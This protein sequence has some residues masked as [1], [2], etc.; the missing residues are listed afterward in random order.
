MAKKIVI[1]IELKGGENVEK[2]VNA[3]TKLTKEIKT[4]K[5]ELAKFEVGTEGYKKASAALNE[6]QE[7]LGDVQDAAKITGNGF[8]RVKGS[9]NLFKESLETADFGKAKAAFSALGTAMKA[10]PIFLLLEGINY[11]IEKFDL[12]G[13]A[14]EFIASIFY[15]ITDAM[16]LTAKESEENTKT[17][18]ENYKKQQEA[19]EERYDAEIAAANIAGKNTIELEKKKQDAIISSLS[20]QL[21]ALTILKNKKGELNEDE[22]KEFEELQKSLTKAS[23]DRHLLELKQIQERKEASKNYYDQAKQITEQSTTLG[24]SEREKEISDIKKKADEQKKLLEDSLNKRGA[25]STKAYEEDAKLKATIDE[26]AQKE[27]NKINKKYG[28]EYKANRKDIEATFKD[29][30]R[31]ELL[32]KIALYEETKKISGLTRVQEIELY[33]LKSKLEKDDLQSKQDSLKETL[34]SKKAS[35]NDLLELDKQFQK[36]SSDLLIKQSKDKADFLIALDKKNTED[37]EKAYTE[38]LIQQNDKAITEQKKLNEKELNA[39][40]NQ[41]N[42]GEKKKA[43]IKLELLQIS[44]EAEKNALDEVQRLNEEA[45]Q[46]KIDLLNKEYD[47]AETINQSV[48]QDA[49][50]SAEEELDIAKSTGEKV[51]QTKLEID[52]KYSDAAK[53]IR[54]D[55]IKAEISAAQKIISETMAV[56]NQVSSVGMGFWNIIA[57]QNEQDRQRDL[58]NTEEYVRDQ[59]K[60]IEDSLADS[61]YA[62]EN[63]YNQESSLRKNQQDIALNDE[64]LTNEEKISLQQNFAAQDEAARL[65]YENKKIQL[66]N[67]ANQA[68]YELNLELFNK[69]EELKEKAFKADRNAKIAQTIISTLSGA[70]AAFT[71]MVAAFPG[72][73][74]LIAGG[75]AAGLVTA[76]GVA[77]VAAISSTEYQKGSAPQKP[78]STPP[79]LGSGA[80]SGASSSSATPS[81]KDSTLYGTGGGQTGSQGGAQSRQQV[82]VGPVRAYVLLGDIVSEMDA[83]AQLRR[84]VT[85]F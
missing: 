33:D 63:K 57:D 76:M 82:D 72:P 27:I 31:D 73:P 66:Q 23:T 47:A 53:K 68:Q 84:K 14:A 85:G 35:G 28:D 40:L 80:G 43:E 65:A 56:F 62:T 54:E 2:T 42:I 16:G 29:F 79:V 32:R 48:I 77:Q 7:K 6:L 36:Q 71:G 46:K 34:K 45:I 74:G 38:A 59:Q 1:P 10:I 50:D 51:T 13:K 83:E 21:A 11:I 69:Q 22:K 20:S 30:E 37:R 55:R 58:A 8:E 12:L 15:K 52:K 81:L 70:V 64:N 18:L 75:I 9:F 44:S 49:I 26:N 25:L 61:L 39:Q 5:G 60:I 78:R 17:Q 4:A 41:A 24:M 19:A 3:F 67:D